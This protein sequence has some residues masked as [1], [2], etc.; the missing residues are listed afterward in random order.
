VGAGDE[1]EG[2]RGREGWA[3]DELLWTVMEKTHRRRGCSPVPRTNPSIDGDSEVQSTNRKHRDEDLI[4]TN[5]TVLSDS[6]SDA[7]IESNFSPK[8]SP[9][10]EPPQTSARN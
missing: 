7:W 10:L 8:L 2:L 9:K 3:N 4:E 5:A 1:G 6:T